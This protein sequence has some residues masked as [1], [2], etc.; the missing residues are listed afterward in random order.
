MAMNVVSDTCILLEIIT[1]YLVT[2]SSKF[3]YRMNMPLKYMHIIV[4]RIKNVN[5]VHGVPKF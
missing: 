5:S 1:V 2:A 4:E 3:L